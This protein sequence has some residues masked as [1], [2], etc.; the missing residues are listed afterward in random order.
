[1]L[2]IFHEMI[3]NCLWNVLVEANFLLTNVLFNDLLHS[4]YRDRCF[5]HA[6]VKTCTNPHLAKSNILYF[7][8]KYC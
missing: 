1:M 4:F 6:A 5:S 3:L 2:E 8:Y 7:L